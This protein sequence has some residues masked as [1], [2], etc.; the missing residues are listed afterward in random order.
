MY[1]TYEAYTAM[2]GTLDETTFNDFEY[3][4]EC[5]VNWFTFNR[6]KTETT[7]PEELSR[8]MYALIKLAKLK[9]DAMILGSQTTSTTEGGVTTTVKT[10]A[11]IASQSNDGVSVSYNSVS[12]TDVFNKLKAFEQGGEIETTVKMY[13]NGVK[14]SLGHKLLYRGTYPDE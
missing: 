10:D 5:I 4:A 8:C 11:T 13:L 6:L 7:Y 12:A 1:I 14:N 2:G 9:A 3:E